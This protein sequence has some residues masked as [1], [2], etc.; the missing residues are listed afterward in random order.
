M[1]G[2]EAITV[3][4]RTFEHVVNTTFEQDMWIMDHVRASGLDALPEEMRELTE[5]GEFNKMAERV[6]LHAYKSGHLFHLLAGTLVEKGEPWTTV[7]AE[8]NA[9]F[10]ATIT[11]P[12]S[13]KALS[14]GIVGVV[15]SFFVNEEGYFV[16]SPKSSG[17]LPGTEGGSESTGASGNL[18]T[19]TP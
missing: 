14:A 18:E 11:D 12:E 16:I 3:E 10:F 5:G 6:V 19:S 13:K 4:G 2:P 8:L 17:D 9:E 15:L 1:E 7:S